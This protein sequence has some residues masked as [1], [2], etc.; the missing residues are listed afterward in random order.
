MTDAKIKPASK[1]TDPLVRRLF[2]EMNRQGISATML[3]DR[4]MGVVKEDTILQWRTRATP[5]ITNLRL[6]FEALGLDLVVQPHGE[7]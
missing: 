2:V 5:T 6:C 3:A 1:A 7:R 4:T